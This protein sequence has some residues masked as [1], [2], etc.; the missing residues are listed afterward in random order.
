MTDLTIDNQVFSTEENETVLDALLRHGLNVPYGC[1][2]GACQSCMLKSLDIS[3]NPLSQNGL[4]DTQIS[5][6]YFLACQC[7]AEQAMKIALPDSE[8]LYSE[9]TI[10]SN[11]ALNR[12]THKI[13][14]QTPDSFAFK[15]G[16]FVNLQRDDGLTRS[17]SIASIPGSDQSIELHIRRLEGGQFST[18]ANEHLNPGDSIRISEALG[19]CFYLSNNSEQNILL[20]GTGTGLAP[21]VGIVKDALQQ[22][23]QGQIYLYHGSSKLEDLYYMDEM[24]NLADLHNNFHYTPCISSGSVPE[25]FSQ[26]RANNIALEKH[27]ELKSWRVYLCGHPDMI[28]QTKTDAFLKGA[29]IQ[30]IYTDPFELASSS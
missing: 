25:G 11:E 14:L 21:L 1:K 15:A 30:D 12:N 19:H 7:I 24:C 26:G 6:N 4:K 28:S 13:V 8:H 22:K 3:P 23:H 5:Q 16:Q 10:I 27:P 18:W 29:S 20:V 2:K 17:Y 9:A